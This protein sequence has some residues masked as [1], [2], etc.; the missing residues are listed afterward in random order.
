MLG[1]EW[2][3]RYENQEEINKHLNKHASSLEAKIEEVKLKI[4]N[5]N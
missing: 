1:N 4:R 5:S 3:T 2:K